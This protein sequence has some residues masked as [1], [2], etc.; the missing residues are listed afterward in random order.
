METE[1]MI[2][3][4]PNNIIHSIL[5][6]MPTRDAARTSI[7]S[8]NW[9][10]TWASHPKLVFD[11][12]FFDETIN[13]RKNAACLKNEF[14]NV[15]NKILLVH[16]GHIVKFVLY[17]PKVWVN[18]SPDIDQ[19]ILFLSRNG[20]KELILFDAN[21]NPYHLPSYLFS[22]PQLTRLSL[23]N[24]VIKP[25]HLSG[26]FRNLV[27]LYMKQIS[28]DSILF[29]TLVVKAPLL[30]QLKLSSC[31]GINHFNV[32]APKLK[33]LHVSNCHGVELMCFRSMAN[34]KDVSIVFSFRKV[35]DVSISRCKEEQLHFPVQNSRKGKSIN[36]IS[37]FD[38]LPRIRR[39][40]LDGFFLKYLDACNVPKRLPTAA[41]KLRHLVLHNFEFNGVDQISC[42]LCL[43]RSSPS[44]EILK[45]KVADEH[46]DNALESAIHYLEAPDCN[47]HTM[48]KLQT[49]HISSSKGSK[50]ELLFIKLLLAC[51]SS[52][53]KMIIETSKKV[54]IN[55]GLRISRELMLFSRASPKAEMIFS[56]STAS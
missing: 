13:T 47:E 19:W 38:Y 11:K 21:H 1:D 36:L 4:L 33:D 14:L 12:Q 44:L 53:E 41:K 30:L 10:F 18:Q 9:R 43:L 6:F 51:S 25:L 32:N 39:L 2:S 50:T 28:F 22:R 48:K 7:L 42:A 16:S 35:K 23:C 26:G 5:D 8:R 52:L 54:D 46:K 27:S 17:I 55:E 31:K 15:I 45:I 37:F 20:I 24:C 34:L 40:T 3:G 29:G 49:V 56:G